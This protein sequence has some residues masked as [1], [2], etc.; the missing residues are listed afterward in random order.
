MG[1]EV[2]R[3]HHNRLDILALGC[4]FGEDARKNAQTAPPHPSAIERLGRTIGCRRIPPPQ[5]I[6]IYEDVRRENSPPGAVEK[7]R[8]V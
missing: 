3:I 4:Q 1:L 8:C 5:A 6:A 7:A 2:G